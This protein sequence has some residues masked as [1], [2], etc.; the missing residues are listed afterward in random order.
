MSRSFK[1]LQAAIPEIRQVLVDEAI[2]PPTQ[3]AALQ[4]L[5]N[6]IGRGGGETAAGQDPPPARGSAPTPRVARRSARLPPAWRF[7]SAP[8]RRNSAAVGWWREAAYASEFPMMAILILFFIR[9]SLAP[10][11]RHRT[12]SQGVW[13][14]WILPRRHSRS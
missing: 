10:R 7:R 1:A 3:T 11:M 14:D 12:S 9:S 6:A 8:S 5:M 13:H 2:L 4:P